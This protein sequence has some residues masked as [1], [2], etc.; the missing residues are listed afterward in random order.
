ML[1]K[2]EIEQILRD[3]HWMVRE[4]ERIRSYL[5]GAGERTVREYGIESGMPKP[6]G[7]TSDP[8]HQEVARREKQWRRV[9]KLE[10]KVRFVQ[11]RIE[12]IS[13]E[14]ERTVMDCML[15]GMSFTAIAYHMKLSKG[16]VNNIKDHIVDRLYESQKNTA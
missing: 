8:V 3:Y 9:E 1:T 7:K 15:D 6:Q 13:D 16:H 4:I 2:S 12:I 14:R 10:G 5:A 11:E